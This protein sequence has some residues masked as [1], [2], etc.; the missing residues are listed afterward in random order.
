[1]HSFDTIP[2]AKYSEAAQRSSSM[3]FEN[4]PVQRGGRVRRWFFLVLSLTLLFAATELLLRA[5]GIGS[6][7]I[8]RETETGLIVR[9]PGSRYLHLKE[10]RNP[11]RYNNLG[12]H[13]RNR[14]HLSPA[15]TRIVV[16]GDSFV[17]GA[18]VPAEAVFSNKAEAL[19]TK[20][21]LSV[22]IVN[23]GTSGSNTG[24]QYLLW[25]DYLKSRLKTDVLLLCL[26]LGDDLAQNH[27]EL[28]L[29]FLERTIDDRHYFLTESG[30]IQPARK[31][32]SPV[33]L[34]FRPLTHYSRI[35]YFFYD[36]LSRVKREASKPAPPELPSAPPG[37]PSG[38]NPSLQPFWNESIRGTM[39]LIRRWKEEAA[40][41]GIRF[42]VMVIPSAS[43]LDQADYG[44]PALN[45][46]AR[47]LR[48]W[49]K[50]E[51][52]PLLEVR[53]PEDGMYRIYSFDGMTPGHFSF[54]GHASTAQ[55]LAEWIEKE[56][57]G[58]K[59]NS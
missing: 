44:H 14:L 51:K 34:F 27:P 11:V 38:E 4:L 15:N 57:S 20:R 48:R 33:I 50:D 12:F 58:T 18:Q 22:E 31:I 2:S 8:H 10:N 25:N 16:I 42:A 46:M 49:A 39:A 45:R 17:E 29:R 35:L 52:V 43:S 6:V 54:E 47:S 59:M 56:L 55:Q 1:M 40:A 5:A 3:K 32:R 9:K 37:N 24:Y 21:G 7:Q 36:T 28:N 19:L 41:D 26:Y 30:D 23:A 13:D 53:F